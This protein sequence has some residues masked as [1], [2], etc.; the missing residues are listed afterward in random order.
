MISRNMDPCQLALSH[1]IRIGWGTGHR[2]R[3]PMI[4]WGLSEEMEFP[5]EG[6]LRKN[7][8]IIAHKPQDPRKDERFRFMKRMERRKKG[9]ARKTKRSMLEDDSG[10]FLDGDGGNRMVANR[11]HIGGRDQREA[12]SA[13]T[14]AP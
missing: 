5:N 7:G 13:E 12:D 14:S 6:L 4:K 9:E 11:K 1:A 3:N 2:E 10:L 8:A